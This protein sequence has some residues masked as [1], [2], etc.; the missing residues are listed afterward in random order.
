MPIVLTTNDVILN[1]DHAW[2]DIEGVQYHYPNQYK[3]KVRSGEPFVYYRG[4]HRKSG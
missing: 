1:P 2:N 4:V 3:T